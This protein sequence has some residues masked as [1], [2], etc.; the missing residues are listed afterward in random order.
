MEQNQN[1]TRSNVKDTPEDLAEKLIRIYS[2]KEIY[3]DRL[4]CALALTQITLTA[5]KERDTSDYWERVMEVLISTDWTWAIAEKDALKTLRDILGE[6]F[7]PHGGLHF[8][9]G[10]P[11][12]PK[13]D[14][15]KE[16]ARLIGE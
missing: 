4:A 1:E 2:K 10:M 11:N 8:Q 7:Q 15:L 5:I 16:I 3:S 13:A 14:E 9:P 12:S 6:D